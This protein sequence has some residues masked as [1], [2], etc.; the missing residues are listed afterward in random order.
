MKKLLIGLFLAINI[1]GYSQ[2]VDC[3][4]TTTS[5]SYSSA[6]GS[7]TIAS[8]SNSF[9]GGLG[10]SALGNQS[11][12][13]G[14]NSYSSSNY[15]ITIGTSDTASGVGGIVLG[16][17]SRAGGTQSLAIGNFVQSMGHYSMVIGSGFEP[18][19][20]LRNIN[21]E[22]LMIGFGSMLPTLSVS[23]SEGSALTGKVGIGNIVNEL[24]GMDIQAKL[25]IKADEEEIAAVLIEPYN[26][27]NAKKISSRD[28]SVNGAYLFLGNT[29]HNI[30]ATAD[31][32]LLFNSESNYIFNEG[33]IGMGV[34]E[35][36]TKLHVNGDI[37]LEND[38]DGIIMKSP[39]GQCWKGNITDDGELT[40]INVDCENFSG[41]SETQDHS[42]IFIYPNPASNKITLEYTGNKTNLRMELRSLNSTLIS[43]HKIQQ[44]ENTIK[45]NDISSQIILA[46]IFDT[47][48]KM[49][50][51]EKIMVSN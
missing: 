29:N 38:F 28:I 43:T 16:T 21:S 1:V 26:W 37:L 8:G 15:S 10:T 20:K 40:F 6:L 36:K 11:F 30:G 24:G 34:E 31:L 44:G 25:H 42:Q 18:T 32:G 22:S 45:L 27:N 13:F 3:Y 19:K 23:A 14:F 4:S 39:N 41:V 51:T 50:V 7:Y 47:D 33:N 12:S 48:G 2:C 35:P 46:S 17:N 5:G 9:A 49:I